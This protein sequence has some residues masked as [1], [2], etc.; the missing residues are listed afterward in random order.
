[1]FDLREESMNLKLVNWNVEW[2]GA[3]KREETMNRVKTHAP[4]VVCLTEALTGLFPDGHSIYSEPDY[5]SGNMGRKRKVM[6]WSKEPWEEIDSLGSESMPPGRFVSGTTQTPLGR[7]TVIGICIPWHDSRARGENAVRKR[8]EDH[9]QYIDTLGPV[10]AQ[11]LSNVSGNWLIVVGDFNQRFGQ[12]TFVPRRLR[13]ALLEAMP[14]QLTVATSAL[15]GARGLRGIDHIALSQD[16]A[17]ES[18]GVIGN[19]H[20]RTKLSDHFGVVANLVA[21]DT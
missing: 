13:A 14:E 6:L 5:G 3:T 16:L 4:D 9:G 2:A 1:M 10:L 21:K 12:G 20:G 19:L 8:W 15:L 7:V 17:A 11:T 18:L